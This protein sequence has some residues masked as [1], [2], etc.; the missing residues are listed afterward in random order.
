MQISEAYLRKVIMEEIQNASVNKE[1]A[2][3]VV[4][5]VGKLVGQNFDL[6]QQYKQG[7]ISISTLVESVSEDYLSEIKKQMLN[8]NQIKFVIDNLLQK[9]EFSA[10]KDKYS[11]MSKKEKEDI[12]TAT[13]SA[14]SEEEKRKASEKI[15]L[16]RQRERRPTLQVKPIQ[17]NA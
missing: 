11:E 13:K 3:D 15:K 8:P 1:L 16:Q 9:R 14:E 5:I 10:F 2:N 7:N 4:D 12:T 17:R 6:Y